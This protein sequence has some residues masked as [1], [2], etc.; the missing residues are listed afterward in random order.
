MYLI[1][2]SGIKRT[3]VFIKRTR[4]FACVCVRL[5]VKIAYTV[6]G[7]ETTKEGRITPR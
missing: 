5:N 7:L 2:C 6:I 1:V 4:A 3:R